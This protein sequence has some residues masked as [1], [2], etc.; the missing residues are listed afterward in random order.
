MRVCAQLCRLWADYGLISIP[1]KFQAITRN[2]NEI[3][4][5][6]GCTDLPVLFNLKLKSQK[7]I[8]NVNLFLQECK[9]CI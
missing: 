6:G 9:N 7:E 2:R 3:T 1:A 8:Y 5:R 4:I